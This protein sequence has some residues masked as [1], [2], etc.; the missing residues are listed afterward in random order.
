METILKLNTINLVYF[1]QKE[2]NIFFVKIQMAICYLGVIQLNNVTWIK[3]KVTF[4]HYAHVLYMLE[5]F[6]I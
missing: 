4:A 6:G 2:R 5:F 3:Y 1:K